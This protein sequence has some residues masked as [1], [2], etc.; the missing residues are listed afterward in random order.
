MKC[1]LNFSLDES[2]LIN[3]MNAFD[4]EAP[5]RK[6]LSERR[7]MGASTDPNH[8]KLFQEIKHQ[9]QTSGKLFFKKILQV[10]FL[11]I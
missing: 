2:E 8:I 6:S 9:R 11:Q 5:Y 3:S 1:T 7:G 10:F 4:R